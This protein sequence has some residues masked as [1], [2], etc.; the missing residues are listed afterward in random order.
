M[1]E[2][3][4]GP[5][6]YDSLDKP[7]LPQTNIPRKENS[8]DW[9]IVLVLTMVSVLFLFIGTFLIYTTMQEVY[10]NPFS[11]TVERAI[12]GVILWGINI[13]PVVLLLGGGIY[14]V[15]WLRNLARKAG[16]VNTMEYQTSIRQVESRVDT[17]IQSYMDIMLQRAKESQ[18]AGVQTLTYDN[19]DRRTMNESDIPLETT[20]LEEEAMLPPG[21]DPVLLTLRN[22][23]LINRS[24]NS[25]LFGF[26]EIDD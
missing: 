20:L 5:F 24:N 7:N 11:N 8:V 22:E 9:R 23:G 4:Q 1:A 15:A 21:N 14:L 12:A 2:K 18:F 19:A 16:L 26:G 13:V 10:K 6:L 25:L 3:L 17:L